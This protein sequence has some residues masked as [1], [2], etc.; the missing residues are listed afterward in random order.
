MAADAL[1]V[2]ISLVNTNNRA[3]LQACLA[4]LPEA[5]AGLRWHVT[6][7][8]NESRDGSAEMVA[9]AFPAARLI[10]PSHVRSAQPSSSASAT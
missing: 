4:S 3:L 7:V 2:E 5:C 9:T 10:R 8:D 1:D 6:V